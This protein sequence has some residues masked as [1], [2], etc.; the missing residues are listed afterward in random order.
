MPTDL[1][2]VEEVLYSLTTSN[3]GP[4]CL[5]DLDA[6]SAELACDVG[7]RLVS[8]FPGLCGRPDLCSA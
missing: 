1:A 2:T 3:Y 4:S 6:V 5:D 8:G 7:Y